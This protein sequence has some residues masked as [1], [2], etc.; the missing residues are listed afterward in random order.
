M[1]N[2][3]SAFGVYHYHRLARCVRYIIRR[4]LSVLLI[5]FTG[6]QDLDMG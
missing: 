6:S 5:R 4:G 1:R 2:Q 3:M